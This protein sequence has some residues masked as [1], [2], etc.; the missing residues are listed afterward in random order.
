[1]RG[2]ERLEFLESTV[3]VCLEMD[4]PD[5]IHDLLKEIQELK[6]EI[7]AEENELSYVRGYN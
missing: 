3:S 4:H 6:D 5:E 2:Q 7:L 1:M